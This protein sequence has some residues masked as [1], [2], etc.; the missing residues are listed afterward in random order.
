MQYVT[1]TEFLSAKGGNREQLAISFITGRMTFTFS[2]SWLL[3]YLSEKTNRVDANTC[4]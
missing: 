4:M 1:R 2:R 3:V